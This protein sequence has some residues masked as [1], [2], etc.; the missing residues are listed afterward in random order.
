MKIASDM[1]RV[2]FGRT[3]VLIG[4]NDAPSPELSYGHS[5]KGASFHRLSKV[6]ILLNLAANWERTV[7]K[8]R[9]GFGRTEVF[10]HHHFEALFEI[11]KMGMI[12]ETKNGNV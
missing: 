1:S 5:L 4:A 7:E 10:R 2:Q 3:E 6:G 12:S 8:T 9:V 11:Y